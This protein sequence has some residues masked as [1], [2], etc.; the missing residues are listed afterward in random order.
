M[1]QKKWHPG[2]AGSPRRG[3]RLHAHV[4]NGS[5]WPA[6]LEFRGAS[7]CLTKQECT[8]KDLH[9]EGCC[10][11]LI[12]PQPGCLKPSVSLSSPSSR[13]PRGF[14]HVWLV[15]PCPE[16]MPPLNGIKVFVF[17]YK[18]S[19]HDRRGTGADFVLWKFTM[20]QTTDADDLRSTLR[21]MGRRSLIPTTVPKAETSLPSKS[22]VMV[23]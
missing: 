11:S 8:R 13:V 12:W 15:W 9:T 22:S 10:T 5:H 19:V 23:P 6:C 14:S 7:Q 21:R 4:L 16:V 17:D 1:G 3:F 2:V 18:A 20:Q